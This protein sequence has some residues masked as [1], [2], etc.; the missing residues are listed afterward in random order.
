MRAQ[1]ADIEGLFTIDTDSMTWSLDGVGQ[2]V[3]PISGVKGGAT[4][5]RV[6]PK[7]SGTLRQVWEFNGKIMFRGLIT[8]GSTPWTQD[9][10]FGEFDLFSGA[11][12]ITAWGVGR[13]EVIG[14]MIYDVSLGQSNTG[15]AQTVPSVGST[16]GS[17]QPVVVLS[18]GETVNQGIK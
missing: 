6:I 16:S 18:S 8:G 5:T 13:I 10:V 2:L 12:V 9:Q 14:T 17:N 3:Q 15:E 7:L 1:W 11:V 4:Q